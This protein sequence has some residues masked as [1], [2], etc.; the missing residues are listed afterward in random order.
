MLLFASL[1][2]AG[3]TSALRPPKGS[4]VALLVFEDLQCPDC[5][6]A[7]PLLHEAAKKYNIPLVQYDFP[8]PMHNWSFEAAVNARWF[9]TKSKKLGDDYR[10]FIFANQPQITPQ[11]L[12]GLTER[13]AADNKV[14]LPFVVDPAGELAAKVKADYAVGQRVGI[15]HTPTIYVVSDTTRGTPFVE[16]VD[17]TQLYQLI[18]KVMKEAGPAIPAPKSSSTAKSAQSAKTGTKSQ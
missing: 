10:L 5:S 15:E 2:W 14:A 16:V 7:A 13:F 1:A 6:R 12:R 8:L 17:R 11:N 3:D 18:D 4:K 9:D